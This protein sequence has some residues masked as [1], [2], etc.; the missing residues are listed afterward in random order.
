MKIP[1]HIGVILDGNR[2]WAEENGLPATR[3]HLEGVKRAKELV[4][5][6][7]ENGIKNLTLFV[8]STENWKRSEKEVNFLMKL[9]EVF[10]KEE[11]TKNDL[12]KDVRVLIV[13]ERERLSERIRKVVETIEEKTKDNK[14]MTLNIALSYGGRGEIVSAIKNIIKKNIPVDDINEQVMRENLSI[15]DL[16]FII[17]TGKEQRIS[18]FFLWQAAYAELYFPNKYWPEFTNKDLLEAL[19]EYDRRKRRFGL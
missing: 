6:A 9:I 12:L 8:F 13:G 10:F 7:K 1:N 5:F 3:G 16:D 2:R 15:P 17:R 14:L 4:S 11:I 19:N 18:N